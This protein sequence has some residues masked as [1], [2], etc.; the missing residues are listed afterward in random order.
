MPILRR[1]DAFRNKFLAIAR[2]LGIEHAAIFTFYNF[3]YASQ[4]PNPYECFPKVSKRK[5][6]KLL[7]ELISYEQKEGLSND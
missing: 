5:F 6:D 1:K 7:K 4:E 3:I 2:D